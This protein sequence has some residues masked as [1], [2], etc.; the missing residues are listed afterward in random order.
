MVN[1]EEWQR[2]SDEWVKTMHASR[3]RKERKEQLLSEQHTNKF[4][5]NLKSQFDKNKPC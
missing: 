3:L 4:I 1:D 2:R 5:Q